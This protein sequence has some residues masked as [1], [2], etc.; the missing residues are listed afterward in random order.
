MINSNTES[1]LFKKEAH[2]AWATFVSGF[3]VALALIYWMPHE[4]AT[5]KP[6][7]QFVDGIASIV[8]II[9]NLRE[10][11]PPYTPFWGL[12]YSV[13]WCLT[14]IYFVLGYVGSFFL[15]EK[16]YRKMII[17]ASGVRFFWSAIF[18][19]VVSAG[20]LSFPWINAYS[21][22]PG[23]ELASVQQLLYALVI[24]CVGYVNGR[25]LGALQLR[26]QLHSKK[27]N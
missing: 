23:N 7:I 5:T 11:V 17:E 19:F 14:P 26:H 13:M 22:Q 27:G 21:I 1:K 12:F 18:I 15:S 20:W 2:Y 9:K 10:H 6:A 25:I 8:P 16:R 3:A 4:W 24:F